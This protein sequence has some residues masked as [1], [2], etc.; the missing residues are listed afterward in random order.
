MT[1]D[2]KKA[3]KEKAQK[4]GA[5]ITALTSALFVI[6]EKAY[7][8]VVPTS[9]PKSITRIEVIH[10][11]DSCSSPVINKINKINEDN[12][13][14]KVQYTGISSTVSNIELRTNSINDKLFEIL[15]K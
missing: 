15:N 9:A 8:S 11:V 13:V 7:N 12:A 3:I 10:I 6:G 2:K 1:A 4:H 5:W 14:L